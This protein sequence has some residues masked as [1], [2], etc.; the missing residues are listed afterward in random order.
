M[1]LAHRDP[2]GLEVREPPVG[3]RL[4]S[5]A[6]PDPLLRIQ[7]GLVPR[8]IGEMEAWARLAE[9]LHVL[10]LVPAGAIDVEPY[11]VAPEPRIQVAER[12]Q[13][14]PPI[15]PRQPDHAAPAKEGGHPAPEVEPGVVLARRRDPEAL[16]A[17]P[18]PP[19]QPGVEREAGL[20]RE[21]DGFPGAERLEFFLAGAGTRGPRRSVPGDSCSW[22]ASAG[23][24]ADGARVGL[25]AP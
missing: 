19:A 1:C 22:P 5:D 9:R 13:E 4:V 6:A 21:G 3:G 10:T 7:G 8:E 25:A 23:S 17:L 11:R 12:V 2:D 15:A 20:I 18:P 14:A 24:P 16:T